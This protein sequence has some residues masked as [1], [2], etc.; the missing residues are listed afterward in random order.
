MP[1]QY[2][3]ADSGMER[4]GA[5]R[6][7]L[8][9][10]VG[11]RCLPDRDARHRLDRVYLFEM[12]KA[13]GPPG[14]KCFGPGIMREEPPVRNFQLPRDTK[15]YDSTTKPED[16]LA[17]YVTAVYVAGG[18]GTANGGGNR[19]W[20]VRI[21]PSFLVGPAR[22]W[23]NNLPKGSINGWLDFE[24]HRPQQLALC[25]QDD[26]EIDR[27]YLTR[28]NSTRNTCDGVIEAQVIAWFCN[29]CR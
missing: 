5:Y 25:L 6:N 8:G 27:D 29:G 16:W 10:H 17:D 3:E 11:E 22:I 15:T 7:P 24:E 2:D 18:G 12:I 19:C 1:E 20:A 21:I 28:W 9:E 4:A 14:L 23:L 26:N 13:E